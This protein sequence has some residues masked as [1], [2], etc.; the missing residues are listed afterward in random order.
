MT[1]NYSSTLLAVSPPSL[2]GVPPSPVVVFR[3]S[4]HITIGWGVTLANGGCALTSLSVYQAVP[5]CVFLLCARVHVAAGG[6][7]S[8]AMV[9]LPQHVQAEPWVLIRL[10]RTR[11]SFVHLPPAPVLQRPH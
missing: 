3:N 11:T 2:P 9:Y 1:S 5:T 8:H 7:M 4:S 10:L 6:V